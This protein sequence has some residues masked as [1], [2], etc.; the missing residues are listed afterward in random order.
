M[1]RHTRL[2]SS[3]PPSSEDKAE[4]AFKPLDAKIIRRLFEYTRPYKRLRNWL[5]LIVIVRSIQ[6]PLLAWAIGAVI[7]G[8]ISNGNARN[9]LLGCTGFLLLTVFTQITFSIRMWMG[10]MI[11]ENVIHDLRLQIF[12]HL[13]TMPMSFY[14]RVPRGRLINRMT[15]DVESVRTGVQEVFFVSCVQGGQTLISAILM[16]WI[17]YRLFLVVVSMAPFVWWLS[18]R[19]RERMSEVSRAMSESFSR[20]TTSL[21]ESVNGI[22]VTQGFARQSVNAELFNQLNADHSRYSIYAARTS[23][24]FLPLL[25]LSS[26]LVTACLIL[27]GGV[28]TLNSS[29]SLHVGVLIQFFFL[30]AVFFGGIQ[31]LGALYNRAM[32]SMAGAERVFQL[33]DLQPEWQDAP[34]ARDLPALSGRVECRHLTFGYDPD[35]PVLHDI[36]FVAEPGQT[37][38]LVGHTGSGKTSIINL[39]AKFYLPQHGEILI[40]GIPLQE[41]KSNGLHRH[42]AI[43]PQQNILFTGS[44][45]ENIR[46]GKPAASDQEITDA[47]RHLDCLDILE[48]LPK[49]LQTL[50]GENGAGLSLGQRQLVC[51]VRAMLADPRI[52][53]LDE[54]T[55]SVDTMT[56]VRIQQSLGKLINKRTCFVIAHRLSTVRHADQVLVMD[57]GR[58]IEQGSHAELLLKQGAYAELYHQF[59]R[60][61][62]G[63]NELKLTSG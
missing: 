24:F 56:E 12:R 41:I 5:T 45:M 58:I 13:L 39:I 43:I 29:H 54:A 26:Q 30:S 42:M 4:P 27:A 8:P 9:T 55:S 57:R 1:S 11:G 28:L 31:S 6:L 63:G 40:D 38:A 50:V 46:I 47:A 15:T 25:E 44:I 35:R 3:P 62:L 37:I 10:Q 51:F 18:R 60:L 21:A 61:G 53:I 32:Q 33:L 23:A 36:S 20:I 22:R 14:N 34:S 59:T 48:A 19:F 52:L 2:H 17:D 7:N 49:G 16:L